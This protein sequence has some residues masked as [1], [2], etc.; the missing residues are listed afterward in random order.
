MG[1]YRP[2]KKRKKK[3]PAL[4]DVCPKCGDGP[5]VRWIDSRAYDGGW[6]PV[7]ALWHHHGRICHVLGVTRE[8]LAG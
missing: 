3:G 2:R 4:P 6:L 5:M 8:E 1:K 7:V